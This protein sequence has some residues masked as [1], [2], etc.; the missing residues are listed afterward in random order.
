MGTGRTG[1]CSGGTTDGWIDGRERERKIRE[2]R[3]KERDSDGKLRW[4]LSY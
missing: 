1:W 3:R 2:R 4:A